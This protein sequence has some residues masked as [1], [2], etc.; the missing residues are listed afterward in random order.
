M[1]GIIGGTGL[2]SLEGLSDLKEVNVETPFGKPSSKVSIGK[3]GNE[4]LAFLPRHGIGHG[5]L[6]HEINYRANIWALKSIGV[7]G[8]ISVSAVGSLREE[9][10]PGDL[11]MPSQYFDWTKG[12]RKSTFFGAGLIGHVSTAETCCP[13]L[14]DAIREA[15]KSLKIKI[16]FNKTYACVQGPRLGTRAE[17][18]F[19]KNAG[20]DLVGMTNVPEVFLAKEAQLPYVTIAVATDYD[21]WLD[22]PAE[23]VSVEKVIARYKE[24]L[25][26]VKSILRKVVSQPLDLASSP[27]RSSLKG[28]LMC[29]PEH[30]E[31]REVFEM[32]QR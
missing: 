25:E 5:I 30:E 1:L 22:D 15:A 23:H 27:A 32:L 12:S 4:E 20:C 3:L 18:F 26:K 9:I 7:A 21:C 11:A 14:R 24:N 16:H 19:L 29:N 2:Y 8:V 6:P 31:A 13:I 17:S 28:A 10:A